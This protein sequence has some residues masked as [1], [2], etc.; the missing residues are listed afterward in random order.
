MP[1][2]K[3]NMGKRKTTCDFFMR[4]PFQKVMTFLGAYLWFPHNRQ[5]VR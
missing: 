5:Q 2:I 3:R 4:P 1:V